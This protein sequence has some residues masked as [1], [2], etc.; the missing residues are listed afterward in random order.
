MNRYNP[1]IHHRRSI[2]L[3][4][5]D[6]S[7]EGL[8]FVTICVQ[9]KECIFGEIV[10]NEM[11]LNDTGRIIETIWNILPTKFSNVLLH[12]F[13][14]M[15]NHF[16]G[17]LEICRDGDLSRPDATSYFDD[18]LRPDVLGVIN[19]APTIG[20]FAGKYNPMFHQNLSRIVRWF[21]GR[22]TFEC[23]KIKPNFVWQRNYHEHIIRNEDAYL[24]ISEYVKF[25]PALWNEDILNPINENLNSNT[26]NK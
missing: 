15:P 6:Y 2:R 17:I 10:E 14:V 8:Y 18:T 19:H 7:Q 11:Y 5:Y 24:K 12:E 22:T 4:G 1:D 23:R 9:N 20:G 13:V 16:H 21:K 25:N 26:I 3:K